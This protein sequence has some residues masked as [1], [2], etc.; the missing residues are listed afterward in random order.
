MPV[1]LHD[2]NALAGRPLAV[3]VIVDDY[4]REHENAK[5]PPTRGIGIKATAGPSPASP[6]VY[7]HESLF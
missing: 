2:P 5:Q 1:S 3:G 7:R 4:S 6:V